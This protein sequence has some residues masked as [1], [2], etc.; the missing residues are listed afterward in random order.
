[1]K[2]Y[3]QINSLLPVLILLSAL[4]YCGVLLAQQ[5]AA[6]LKEAYDHF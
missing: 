2:R 4:F 6:D 3:K 1:M 5:G